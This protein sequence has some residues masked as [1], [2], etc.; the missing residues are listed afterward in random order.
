VTE[1]AS[2]T[3]KRA[4][5]RRKV[6]AI[7]VLLSMVGPMALNI[8][9]PVLPAFEKAFATSRE[10]ATLVLS[11]FLATMAVSQLF[12]G[13]LSDRFGRRP[14]L[15]TGLFMFVVASVGAVFA[16]TI[17]E[18]LAARVVQALGATVGLP[19]A[20]TIVRDLFE[21]E[22]AASMIGYLTMAM[23]VVPMLSPAFGG[24]LADGFGWPA[25]FLACAMFGALALVA[26]G[27]GMPE[28]R[29]ASL[30]A[31][32]G[33][34]VAARSF[35]LLRSRS[36]LAFAG[37]NACASSV[38]FAFQGGA[39]FIVVDALGYDKAVYGLWF[40]LGGLG[41]MAGNFTSGRL[42]SRVGI[43]RMVGAGN[44]VALAGALACLALALVP[45]QQAWALF[46]P[47]AI[48][49][50]ANG[51]VIPNAIAAAVSVN[52]QAAGAASGLAGFMQMG[53]SAIAS[54]FV[55][56]ITTASAVPMAIVMVAITAA[57]IVVAKAR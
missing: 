15:V 33:R 7:L 13:P 30:N 40:A 17:G 6:L 45:V 53:L 31:T 21:R 34:E 23:V 18:L 25:I 14:V 38:F 8:A 52:P 36:F 10:N 19:L 12:L 54:L 43:E 35:Q 41:Y 57:G 27:F 44:A 47:M 22:E 9:M 42:S 11:L 24:L 5:P 55:G 51:L 28:T 16:T 49:A 37:T 48:I 39:P 2:A 26:V 32:T 20:R 3:A 46:V 1:I 56:W 50:Y 29:P 4:P